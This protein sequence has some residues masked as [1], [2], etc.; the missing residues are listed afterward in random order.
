MG[1]RGVGGG[2]F[3]TPRRRL[4]GSSPLVPK[5][6]GPRAPRL[7]GRLRDTRRVGRLKVRV[8]RLALQP[9]WKPAVRM[10]FLGSYLMIPISK[11]GSAKPGKNFFSCIVIELREI[12][13]RLALD[14]ISDATG[15]RLPGGVL[16]LR[17]PRR[18]R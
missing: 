4:R 11:S 13:H 6:E 1:G 7:R 18:R 17:C 8:W 14:R 9:V 2:C 12:F 16:R 15:N 5:C 10:V 3:L